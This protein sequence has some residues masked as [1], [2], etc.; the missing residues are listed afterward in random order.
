VLA[1]GE[2]A[3]VPD[4]AT[5]VTSSPKTA[6]VIATDVALVLVHVR[7][8]V[9]PA[10]TTPGETLR[11]IVGAEPAGTTATVIEFVAAFPFAS[12]AVATYVVVCDGETVADPVNGSVPEAK[13]GEMENETAFVA[14]H[15]SVV[16]CPCTIV[17]EPD[18]N[19]ITACDGPLLTG[20][21]V[22]APPPQPTRKTTIK[23]KEI[24]RTSC[25]T[26]DEAFARTMAHS[27][28]GVL[29]E[30]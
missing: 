2:T 26:T 25:R 15:V 16:L 27:H 5:E 4:S 3:A 28:P 23:T 24:F 17:L 19:A 29:A 10:A 1:V 18:A 7:F 6:G 30:M 13:E 9:C 8:A 12:M 22:T 21:G 20:G 14:L 11:V